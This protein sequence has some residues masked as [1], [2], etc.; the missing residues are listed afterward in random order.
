MIICVSLIYTY[1]YMYMILNGPLYLYKWT[2]VLY[3]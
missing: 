3:M 2:V 1:D